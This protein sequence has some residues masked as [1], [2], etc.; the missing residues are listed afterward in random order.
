MENVDRKVIRPT[1]HAIPVDVCRK[2]CTGQVIITLAGACKELVDNSLDAGA[3]TIGL[4]IPVNNEEKNY[5]GLKC[6]TIMIML[7]EHC[8]I[9]I[10]SLGFNFRLMLEQNNEL[11]LQSNV[12][13]SMLLKLDNRRYSLNGKL[14]FHFDILVHFKKFLR[15]KCQNSKKGRIFRLA[16]KVIISN[17]VEIR[18]KKLGF[19]SVEVIDDGLGIHSINFNALCN[20]LIKLFQKCY[21]V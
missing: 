6:A 5:Y 10:Y 12:Y 11:Q 20:F 8:L 4:F 15:N 19:E 17:I 9:N 3:K 16:W 7:R 1:I 21:K 14:I 13:L 2:I 18:V